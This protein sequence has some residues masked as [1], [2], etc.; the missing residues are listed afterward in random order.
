MGQDLERSEAIVLSPPNKTLQDFLECC[1]ERWE[2][3][4]RSL[5]LFFTQARRNGGW[6]GAVSLEVGG[7]DGHPEIEPNTFLIIH[8]VTGL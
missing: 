8:L 1:L 4:E 7:L 5:I 2:S 6:E 3:H